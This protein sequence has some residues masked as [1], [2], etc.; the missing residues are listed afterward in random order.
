MGIGDIFVL[1]MT[2]LPFKDRLVGE[3]YA[4]K[5]KIG[6]TSDPVKIYPVTINTP[7]TCDTSTYLDLVPDTNNNTRKSI[8]YCEKLASVV[9]E[10]DTRYFYMEETWG[11]VCW[12]N[13]KIINKNYMTVDPFA[14]TVLKR[15]PDQYGNY[16]NW[17]DVFFEYKRQVP[18]N[19]IFSRYTYDEPEKQFMIYPFGAFAFDF[20]VR[21][22]IAQECLTDVTLDPDLC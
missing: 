6:K 21:F 5:R 14:Q 13:M 10:R 3:T 9:L 4:L 7:S 15:I 22:R 2:D 8:I 18:D 20:A 1:L 16:G 17:I 12:L 11:L 19:E